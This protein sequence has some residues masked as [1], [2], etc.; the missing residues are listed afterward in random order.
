MRYLYHGCPELASK[1][2]IE[3][4]FNRS[5]CGV[6]GKIY[7]FIR[8]DKYIKKFHKAVLMDEECIFPLMQIIQIDMQI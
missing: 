2:I 6:N 3:R 8:Y 4:G 1:K 5:Y 7:L